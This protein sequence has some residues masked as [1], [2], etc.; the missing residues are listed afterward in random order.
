M[1]TPVGEW[2]W[3][4]VYCPANWRWQ[5]MLHWSDERVVAVVFAGI[6]LSGQWAGSLPSIA[7][8]S[9]LS[10]SS[11]LAA[12]TAVRGRGRRLESLEENICSAEWC[13]CA[14]LATVAHWCVARWALHT[15]IERDLTHL[16]DH[17]PWCSSWTWR[18]FIDS[19]GRCMWVVFPYSSI[20]VITL[21]SCSLFLV[22]QRS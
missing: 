4:R 18:W 20:P 6:C 10:H 14:L 15:H 7:H 19:G 2:N 22:F 5:L 17:K 21:L 1:I 9:T 16:P 11:S 13:M 3:P 12:A 8:P